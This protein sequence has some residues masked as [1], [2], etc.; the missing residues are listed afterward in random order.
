MPAL[1]E[2]EDEIDREHARLDMHKVNDGTMLMGLWWAKWGAKVETF[3][4]EDQPGPDGP[5]ENDE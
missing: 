2:F 4:G 5:E 1:D 3:L